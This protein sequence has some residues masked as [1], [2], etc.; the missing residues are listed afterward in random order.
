MCS[1]TLAISVASNGLKFFQAQQANRNARQQARTQNERAK[2]D[3]IL[4]ET[5]ENYKIRQS[6]AGNCLRIG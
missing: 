1:P 4:K 5:A 2:K 6:R 3:R